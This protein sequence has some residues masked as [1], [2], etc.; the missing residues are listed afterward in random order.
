MI[1]TNRITNII[2]FL[3]KF[4]C[5]LLELVRVD[6]AKFDYFILYG[7]VNQI[8]YFS[9]LFLSFKLSTYFSFFQSDLRLL[10]K[11]IESGS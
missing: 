9:N 4:S 5:P 1:S 7:F 2:L 6:S 10:T 11:M 3:I 8:Y